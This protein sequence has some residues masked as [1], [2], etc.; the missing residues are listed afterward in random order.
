MPY[1]WARR[2]NRYTIHLDKLQK[3]FQGEM[4]KDWLV[5][6]GLVLNITAWLY[7]YMS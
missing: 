5:C 2:M 6:V 7:L 3:Y 4:G 1:I